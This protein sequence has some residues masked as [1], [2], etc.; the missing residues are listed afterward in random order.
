M[1]SSRLPPKL[2]PVILSRQDYTNTAHGVGRVVG[3]LG[4][5]TGFAGSTLSQVIC[6][7]HVKK[8]KL[9]VCG[10]KERLY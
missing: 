1:T 10:L 7:T 2:T 4:F 9:R 5:G 6:F 8:T 3:A